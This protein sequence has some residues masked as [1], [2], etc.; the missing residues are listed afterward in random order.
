MKKYYIRKHIHSLLLI[1]IF[2]FSCNRQDKALL[3][4]D[5]AKNTVIE[6]IKLPDVKKEINTSAEDPYFE[7][8]SDTI[9]T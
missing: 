8:P 3:T 6:Q 5:T 7:M 1:L 4:K 9:S 2:I